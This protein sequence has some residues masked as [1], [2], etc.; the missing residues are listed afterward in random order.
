MKQRISSSVR[1]SSHS[2]KKK[3]RCTFLL[4]EWSNRF[5]RRPFTPS[6]FYSD[7]NRVVTALSCTSTY[8]L[9]MVLM[10]LKNSIGIT[11]ASLDFPSDFTDGLIVVKCYCFQ[12]VREYTERVRW[13][14]EKQNR[15]NNSKELWYTVI[16]TV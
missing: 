10:L 14:K 11:Q 8:F 15:N 4:F 16:G 1:Y 13:G 7:G 5:P 6:F 2:F 9:M 3:K 12:L